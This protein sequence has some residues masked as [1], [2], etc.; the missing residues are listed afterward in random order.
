MLRRYL[1]AH[2][3]QL[4]APRPVDPNQE[5]SRAAQVLLRDRPTGERN[6]DIYV[7]YVGDNQG[8]ELIVPRTRRSLEYDQQ[9]ALVVRALSALQ[10]RP[11]EDVVTDIRLVG[12][13]VVQT[14]IPD[15]FVLDD[16]IRLAVARNFIAGIRN[17]LASTAT[18]EI[19]PAPFFLR[20]R[21]EALEYADGCR[22]GHTFR[23]SFGFTV[24]SPLEPNL[25]PPLP[26]LPSPVPFE[27]RV[28]ERLSRGLT[29][30][31][32]SVEAD[33]IDP[34]VNN[35]RLAF[36]ANVCEQFAALVEETTKSEILFDIAYSP[37]W[38][39]ATPELEQPTRFKIGP[40][41]VEA[42][43][44][45]AKVLRTEI[46]P[47]D[48]TVF[49]RVIRLASEVN[50]ADLTD[51]M[52]EREVAILWSSETLGDVTVRASLTPADYLSAL[53]AH[54]HGLPVEVSGTL[55]RRGRAWILSNPTNFSVP[56]NGK[57]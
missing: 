35:V 22:F 52:G 31:Q 13:D 24:E 21:K 14:R 42:V 39:R 1:V 8:I 37:E 3:W 32:I 27:R 41:H 36:S 15:A 38:P 44:A 30:T 28:V 56:P 16:A 17:L 46:K 43:R 23:G 50:P 49:G 19:N 33:T 47:W 45:A 7:S 5:K 29:A 48:E 55:E 2:N 54:A 25:S 9:V 10:D 6:F 51:V 53:D 11:D 18:T 12:S 4:A 20:Q 34:L 40:A 26:G 57:S